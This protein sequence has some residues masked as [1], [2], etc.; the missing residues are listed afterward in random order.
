MGRLAG[1][2]RPVIRPAIAR[3]DTRRVPGV[4]AQIKVSEHSRRRRSAVVYEQAPDVS[5][6]ISRASQR[7]GKGGQAGV[8]PNRAVEVA[9][10]EIGDCEVSFT[11]GE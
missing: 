4:V 11:I 5:I 9:S 10:V 1:G 3:K 7:A 8:A 2:S 6:G